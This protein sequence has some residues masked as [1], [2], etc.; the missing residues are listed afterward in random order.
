MALTLVIPRRHLQEVS[1]LRQASEVFSSLRDESGEGGST[2]PDG[3]V[4]DGNAVLAR[5]SYN[6]RV[7][8]PGE[9]KP[10]DRPIYDPR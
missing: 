7:W 5:V 9:W 6:G 4:R 3:I 10:G 1:T 8:L 2:F